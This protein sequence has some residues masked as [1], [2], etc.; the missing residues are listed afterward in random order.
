MGGS[1]ASARVQLAVDPRIGH[2]TEGLGDELH[3]VHVSEPSGSGATGE[4]SAVTV[5]RGCCCGDPERHPDIDHDR[6]L[7]HLRERLEP[8]TRVRTSDCLLVCGNSNVLVVSPSPSARRAGARPL[9]LA[10]ILSEALQD[11]VAD[12]IG[13]GGPGAAPLP[14]ELLPHV[15]APFAL[16]TPDDEGLGCTPGASSTVGQCGEC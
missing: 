2:V 3:A 11:C 5:C 6:L 4:R 14:R 7:R 1:A 8:T 12:W 13:R 10:R 16:P 15:S 9:W